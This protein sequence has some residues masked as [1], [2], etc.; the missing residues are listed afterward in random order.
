MTEIF[1][2]ANLVRNLE[3][4]HEVLIELFMRSLKEGHKRGN[5]DILCDALFNFK[6]TFQNHLLKENV[7]LF[8]YLEQSVKWHKNSFRRVR[9]FRKELNNSSKEILNF[10]KRYER[11]I[12]A[13]VMQELYE[14]EFISVK[15]TLVHRIQ[16]VETKMYPLYDVN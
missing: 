8:G 15:N 6:N 5:L 1:Y 4:E 7:K 13:L 9:E 10:C 16:L 11:P 12:D 3:K 14:K 2:D